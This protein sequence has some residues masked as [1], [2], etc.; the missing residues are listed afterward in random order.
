MITEPSP[1]HFCFGFY[2]RKRLSELRKIKQQNEK[3]FI[4]IVFKAIS[5]HDACMVMLPDVSM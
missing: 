2:K 5:H 3:T 4:N 1:D